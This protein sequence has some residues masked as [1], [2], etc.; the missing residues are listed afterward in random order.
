MFDAMMLF[1]A[2]FFF[3]TLGIGLLLE[4]IRVPWI[5]G[6]LIFGLIVSFYN[7]MGNIPSAH[8]IK[9]L[10]Q[11]GMYFLL[12]MI[13]I[14]INIKEWSK[15]TGTITKIT[16]STIAV[17]TIAGAIFFHYVFNVNWIIST[18]AALSFA[19]VGEAILI[20]VLDEFHLVNTRI[21]QTIIGAGV[22]DDIF[23]VFTLIVVT[24]F[25]AGVATDIDELFINIIIISVLLALTIW[26]T[27]MEEKVKLLSLPKMGATVILL[28][29]L[30]FLFTGFGGE[31]APLGA[32]FAGIGAKQFIPKKRLEAVEREIK[33]M[34]YGFF[35]PFFFFSVGFSSDIN[36]IMG[37][38]GIVLL[39]TFISYISKVI[40]SL[41]EIKK[42]GG[43]G[44][45][46]LGTALSIRFSTS[47]VI[48][49][50]LL[51]ANIIPVSMY[52]VIIGTTVLLQLI[53]PETFSMM[54]SKWR[55]ELVT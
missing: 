16:L 53:I 4:K 6:A 45:L 32:L 33:G 8:L 9:F 21:G 36:Y 15:Q 24:T 51:D 55:E 37:S 40:G 11:L 44:V 2:L 41:I 50:M 38:F 42:F 19:T 22:L 27:K 14:E 17:A 18:L 28:V 30:L 54:M 52:S 47:L 25:F 13:G 35:A 23:E 34:A 48:S 10:S 3:S 39:A 31:S 29:G 12:F 7:P 20:P 1:I 26:F 46:A 43:K 49:K 5:F